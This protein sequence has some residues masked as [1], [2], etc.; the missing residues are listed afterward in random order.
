MFGLLNWGEFL[1]W[2]YWFLIKFIIN[3]LQCF[4]WLICRISLSFQIIMDSWKRYLT[5]IVLLRIY[6][7]LEVSIQF[8]LIF[9]RHM[10]R[11]FLFISDSKFSHEFLIILF[12]FASN[13]WGFTHQSWIIV[14]LSRN[15][16]YDHRLGWVDIAQTQP[17]LLLII[18][19][20]NKTRIW[21]HII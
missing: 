3:N 10:F 15:I 8:F 18:H 14:Y 5:I 4:E 7:S 2:N 20:F 6:V 17:G 13:F 9:A 12:I 21:C 11:L 1:N 16:I 19:K